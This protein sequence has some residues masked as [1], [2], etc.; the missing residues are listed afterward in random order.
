MT[1][2]YSWCVRCIRILCRFPHRVAN[3]PGMDSQCPVSRARFPVS[4]KFK[5]SPNR[6]ILSQSHYN[7]FLNTSFLNILFLSKCTETHLQQYK[8]SKICGMWRG[9]LVV[10]QLLHSLALTDFPSHPFAG[11][12]RISWSTP[13][14]ARKTINHPHS[15]TS[16]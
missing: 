16:R 4:R 8:K 15:W 10:T 11:V 3:H 2:K 1:H 6:V 7:Y 14:H 9:I 5:S 13:S 12:T